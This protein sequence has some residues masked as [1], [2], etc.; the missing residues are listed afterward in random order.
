MTATAADYPRLAAPKTD[1]ELLVWPEPRQLLRQTW[2][3]HRALRSLEV[4]VLGVPL[5]RLRSWTRRWLGHRE[6]HEV[7]VGTGHQAELHHPGVWVKNAVIASAARRLGGKAIHFAVDTDA[8]KHL[9]Y[10]WPGG[11]MPITE[12]PELGHARWTGLVKAPTRAHVLQLRQAATQ[13]ASTWGFAPAWEDLFD[14]LEELDGHQVDLASALSNAQHATDRGLGLSYQAFAASPLWRSTAYLV[15][16]Y[17]ICGRCEEFAGSY[18]ACLGE[19]RQGQGISSPGRPM[20]DLSIDGDFCETPFWLDDLSDGSRKRATLV[21]EQGRWTLNA[22]GLSFAFD[23]GVKD[24]WSAAEGFGNWLTQQKLRLSPRALM[25]TM[26]VR[27]FL[28]D[29]FVHGIGGGLYDQVTDRLITAWLGCAPPAF[30]VAT[31]TLYFPLAQG[32][33]RTSVEQLGTEIRRLQQGLLGERKME[34]VRQIAALPRGSGERGRL[35]AQMRR[36]VTT[37][38]E[39]D[40][41]AAA[42]AQ[43]LEASRRLHDEDEVLFN[44]E[45]PYTLQTRARL[46]AMIAKVDGLFQS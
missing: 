17:D 43:R 40:P 6:D 19:F 37:A 33:Q 12:D 30:A 14:K 46:E 26:F 45:W 21:R 34:M 8:P 36:E 29:Q 16:V 7:I 15:M 3:N 32:R 28:V 39:Q 9:S 20:P 25:L 5:P 23:P 2:E 10:R 22:D 1:G 35:F 31:A 38:I 41:Q 42:Y 24:G 4:K 13:A 11:G 44:R 27:M 18:N